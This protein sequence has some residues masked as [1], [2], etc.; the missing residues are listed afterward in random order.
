LPRR[1]GA[2]ADWLCPAFTDLAC[3][4]GA[5]GLTEVRIPCPTGVIA[6]Q[7]AVE[8]VVLDP[9]WEPREYPL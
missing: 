6:A 3:R 7:T 9:G 4:P 1:R 2:A 5:S 8:Y